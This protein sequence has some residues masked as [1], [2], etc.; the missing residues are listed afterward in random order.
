MLARTL[1]LV[2]QPAA[3]THTVDWTLATL[4]AL[5][6]KPEQS[7]KGPKLLGVVRPDTTVF[8]LYVHR[9]STGFSPKAEPVLLWY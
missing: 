1:E 2:S 8:S 9:C 5:A 6:L 3:W 7:Q 4:T